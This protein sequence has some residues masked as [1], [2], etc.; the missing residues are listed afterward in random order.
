[1]ANR[2]LFARGSLLL[3]RLLAWAYGLGYRVK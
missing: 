3:R 2:L 1:M